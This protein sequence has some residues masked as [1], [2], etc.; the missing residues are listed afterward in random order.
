MVENVNKSIDHTPEE[1][2]PLLKCVYICAY[3]FNVLYTYFAGCW[4]RYPAPVCL[5]RKQ[6]VFSRCPVLCTLSA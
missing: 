2:K 4:L 3:I 5:I 6:R 1:E